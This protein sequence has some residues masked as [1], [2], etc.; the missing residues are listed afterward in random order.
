[1]RPI[2]LWFIFLPAVC[3]LCGLIPVIAGDPVPTKT[4]FTVHAIGWV[5]TADGKTT[6]VLDEKYQPGLL[7]VEKLSEIWVLYWFDRNDT[8]EKRSTL[9][10]HPRGNPD[11]PLTGVFATRSPVR[12]NLIALSRCKILSVRGNV[13]EI[14]EIDALADTPVLDLKP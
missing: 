11:N 3:G 1:M 2:V 7:G 4:A 9:R 6:I 14:D 12:P 10:V 8:P 13:I 5:R